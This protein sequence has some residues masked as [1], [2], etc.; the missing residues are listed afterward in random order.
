[1]P[2]NIQNTYSTKDLA[3]CA[4]LLILKQNL[5]RLERQGKT[6]WFVFQN[7]DICE[8]L[9]SQFFFGELLVNA[10]EYHETLVKLKNRIFAIT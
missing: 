9:S 1:M 5:I 4:A 7:K 8:K 10:R 2:E 3:E 6:C